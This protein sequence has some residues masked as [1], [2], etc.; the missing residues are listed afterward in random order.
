MYKRLLQFKRSKAFALTIAMVSCFSLSAFAEENQEEVTVT[1]E[2]LVTASRTEQELK[3]TPSSAQVITRQE[4]DT[5]GAQTVQDV[6]RLAVG[7]ELPRGTVGGNEVMIRGMSSHHTMILIDGRRTGGEDGS[8]LGA[9]YDLSRININDVE[10]IEIVRGPGSSL[11]GADAMGGVINVITRKPS[12]QQLSINTGAGS[13]EQ[14]FGMKFD[15]GKIGRWNWTIGANFIKTRERGHLDLGRRVSVL[16][17]GSREFYNI[18]GKY[19][20][21]ENKKIELFFDRVQERPTYKGVATNG[22]RYTTDYYDGY[23]NS[24]G[25]AYKGTASKSNYELRAYTTILDR[26]NNKYRN[27]VISAGTDYRKYKNFIIDGKNSM[28]IGDKHLFTFGGELRYLDY[29]GTNLN[30]DAKKVGSITQNNGVAKDVRQK[31]TDY[32]SLYLQ[33]EWVISEALLLIPSLRYDYNSDFGHHYSPKV[34]L[35]YKFNDNYRLKVNYGKGFRAPSISE[36]YMDMAGLFISNP[37]LKPEEAKSFD[38]SFEADMGKTSLKTTYFN[39]DVSN[40][41][42]MKAIGG[43]F[44]QYQNTSKAKIEGLEFE[45]KQKISNKFDLKAVYTSLDAR[46]K[47]T[48]QKLTFRA[49]D[50][51]S[52]QLNYHDNKK[53]GFEALLWYEFKDDYRRTTTDI[54]SYGS[55]N[56]SLNKKFTD[57]MSAYVAFNNILDKKIDL[58][59][60]YGFSWRLGV[61]FTI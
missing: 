49:D 14:V 54:Y 36:I 58:L 47:D 51:Y 8:T 11:Y 10:R 35:N 50:T 7:I 29:K 3:E 42:G 53:Y 37:N 9:R 5:I 25:I 59:Y 41:I 19:D 30:T 15:T 12:K 61:N 38:V 13:D 2:V 21:N 28:Q 39:N 4:I 56:F 43:G 26:W 44:Y 60:E 20:I 18:A 1:R 34:G 24:Y 52:I 32:R 27:N 6:L 57:K 31:K 48:N 22:L 16:P 46:N 45:L 40:L 33:D 23:K 55:L 17:F